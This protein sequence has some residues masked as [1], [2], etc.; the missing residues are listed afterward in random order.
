[1]GEHRGDVAMDRRRTVATGQR[2]GIEEEGRHAGLQVGADR[3]DGLDPQREEMA[4]LVEREFGL[5][6]VVARLRVA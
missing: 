1:M 3:G 4:V 2:P 5:R 6:D